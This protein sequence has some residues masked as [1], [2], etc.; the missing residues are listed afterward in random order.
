MRRE[1]APRRAIL[2]IHWG[3]M[4][5]KKTILEP[6][7]VLQVGRSEKMGLCLPHDSR[8]SDAHFELTWDGEVCRLRDLKST[9][10]LLGGHPIEE[11]LAAHGDWIRAGSTDFTMHFEEFTRQDT[12]DDS[13]GKQ[14]AFKLLSSQQALYAVLDAARSHRVLELLQESVEEHRSL[15]EGPQGAALEEVAPYLVPLPPNSRLLKPLVQEGWGE[16]WGIYLTCPLS[17]LETR[18]HL[19]KFLMAEAEGIDG[20]LYFRFYDPRVLKGFLPTCSADQRREFFGPISN[21][22]HEAGDESLGVIS[23]S[24]TS[25]HLTGA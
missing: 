3:P 21:L 16:S 25:T 2:R 6:G 9:G 13:A 5:F 1:S 14:E 10:T 8:M 17:P 19:R 20:R 22:F 24:A 7:Q 23:A 18:R 11:G 4:A 12:L 15:Y